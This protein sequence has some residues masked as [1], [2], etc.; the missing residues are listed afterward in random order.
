MAPMPIVQVMALLTM[1][2]GL[3]QLE[4]AQSLAKLA[5]RAMRMEFMI[6]VA[7]ITMAR[8][9]KAWVRVFL[10]AATLPGSPPENI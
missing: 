7:S 3:I 2:A 5:P 8:P 4:V 9:I 6:T 10:P 1:E